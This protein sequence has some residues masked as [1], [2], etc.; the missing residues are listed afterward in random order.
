[1]DDGL[2]NWF[3][4]RQRIVKLSSKD[5]CRALLEDYKTNPPPNPEQFIAVGYFD[6]NR[7]KKK[8]Y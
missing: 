7:K 1:M 2:K 3:L 8:I 5:H 6:E 4:L